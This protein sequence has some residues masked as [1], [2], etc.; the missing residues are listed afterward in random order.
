MTDA[1]WDVFA[2]VDLCYR[3]SAGARAAAV[4]TGDAA[5]SAIRAE[6]AVLVPVV[7][8]YRPGEFVLREL[9]PLHAVLA[10]V[11][12][13]GLLVIDG[14]A[15]LDREGRP[16]L[17]AHARCSASRSS[18]WPR[19]GS[20]RQPHGGSSARELRPAVVHHRGRDTGSRGGAGQHHPG[21]IRGRCAF[22]DSG[23]A[24]N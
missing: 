2:A 1:R 3:S 16:G 14:Y 17:G 5:F 6:W 21:A 7:L 22:F 13:F 4:T 9:P 12:N 11:R 10:Q 8:P 18:A 20:A 19:P 23:P 15:D 24:A